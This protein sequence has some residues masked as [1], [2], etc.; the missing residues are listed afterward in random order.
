MVAELIDLLMFVD[1]LKGM[2]QLDAAI[3]FTPRQVLEHP[4]ASMGHLV[5][6]QHLSEQ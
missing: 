4:F 1:M 3:R 5:C 2:L 6:M